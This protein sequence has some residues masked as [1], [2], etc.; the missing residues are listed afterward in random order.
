M[1]KE[2]IRA[3]HSHVCG[4]MADNT[5]L[6]N[7]GLIY[8][9]DTQSWHYFY[10]DPLTGIPDDLELISAKK[11]NECSDS[12]LITNLISEIRIIERNI[13]NKTEESLK[14]EYDDSD[15]LTEAQKHRLDLI[16][17]NYVKLCGAC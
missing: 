4:W 15:D 2:V 10:D 6:M 3:I 1:N 14:T 9:I 11:I 8:S 17:V 7:S 5:K 12:E 13:L 16:A